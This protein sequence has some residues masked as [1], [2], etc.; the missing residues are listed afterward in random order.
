MV[1]PQIPSPYSPVN[2]RPFQQAVQ[3]PRNCSWDILGYAGVTIEIG[4]LPCSVRACL[5]CERFHRG[6]GAEAEVQ[7]VLGHGVEVLGALL[8]LGVFAH[9]AQFRPP[10]RRHP[11][12]KYMQR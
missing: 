12:M 2:R 10:A 3:Q 6:V 8:D 4:S 9:D 7:D 5:A 1:S 11:E